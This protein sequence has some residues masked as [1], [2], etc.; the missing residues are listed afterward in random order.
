MYAILTL[1]VNLDDILCLPIVVEGFIE[2][3]I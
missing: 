3:T 1:A 2:A